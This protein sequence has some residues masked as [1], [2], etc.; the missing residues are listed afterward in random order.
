[1]NTSSGFA[2]TEAPATVIPAQDLQRYFRLR[3]R[4][5]QANQSIDD[6]LRVAQVREDHIGILGSSRSMLS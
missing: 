6:R 1:V 4:G 5:S 2:M 3:T